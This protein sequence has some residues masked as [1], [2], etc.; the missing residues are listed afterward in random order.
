MQPIQITTRLRTHRKQ[1]GP[2]SK[3]NADKYHREHTQIGKIQ[4][5]T[6]PYNIHT[7]QELAHTEHQ[8]TCIK[9]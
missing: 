1:D 5:D 7:V 4:K 8:N 9:L 2:A 6:K 3:F